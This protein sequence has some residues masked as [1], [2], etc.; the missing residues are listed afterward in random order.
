MKRRTIA[1]LLVACWALVSFFAAAFAVDCRG[2]SEC[3]L[4]KPVV[5]GGIV[6]KSYCKLC[7]G[8]RGDGMARAAKLY[9]DANL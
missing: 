7:H 8:E 4:Q 6:F 1:E 3:E 2:E 5:R 9:G